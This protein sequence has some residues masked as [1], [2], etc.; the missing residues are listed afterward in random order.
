[1]SL[2]LII[3]NL[4]FYNPAPTGKVQDLTASQL[5]STALLVEWRPVDC[6]HQNS[7]I[8]RYDLSYAFGLNDLITSRE[9]MTS[10]S[11]DETSF[12]V[13]G[14]VPRSNYTFNV[15]AVGVLDNN[16]NAA[17]PNVTVIK[18]T[19]TSTGIFIKIRTQ[20]NNHAWHNYILLLLLID[21]LLLLGD[22]FVTN[23]SIITFRDIEDTS[24][25]GLFCITNY[26]NCC[27]RKDG[28][29]DGRWHFPD[30]ADVQSTISTRL[31][32]YMV[33]GPGK[34]VL[35]R[36]S[37]SSNS[38]AGIYRCEIPIDHSLRA[39]FYVGIYA[40]NAGAW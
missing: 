12:I 18:R 22:R 1:M 39:S 21:V 14:L 27:R 40:T 3:I 25:N 11:V 26:T 32:M 29:S 4:L 8:V 6:I 38:P 7:R 28:S 35:R 31:I 23:N 19:E 17:G 34:V 30:S 5:N 10:L 20:T 24:S 13:T 36:V 9:Q 33:R 16:V 37:R 15:S 2:S